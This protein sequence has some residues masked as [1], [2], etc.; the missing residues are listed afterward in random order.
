MNGKQDCAH[1]SSSSEE[2]VPQDW[3]PGSCRGLSCSGAP[4]I[5]SQRTMGRLESS[6]PFTL[7]R[8]SWSSLA[9]TSLQSFSAMKPLE[10]EGLSFV[11]LRT[12]I[13]SLPCF[14]TPKAQDIQFTPEV[15]ARCRSP[16]ASFQAPVP[17]FFPFS[18]PPPHLR[19]LATP[20]CFSAKL[21]PTPA[22]GMGSTRHLVGDRRVSVDTRP[23]QS[24]K[25]A[26][27][28]AGG[29]GGFMISAWTTCGRKKKVG[30]FAFCL[31]FQNSSNRSFKTPGIKNR[32]KPRRGSS[33][34]HSASYP[35]GSSTLP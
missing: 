22:L 11:S 20:W 14:R 33:L 35:N 10:G 6:E 5:V 8:I 31:F 26:K 9:A 28:Q 23:V 30:I 12:L 29:D 3:V 34:I 15:S 24:T 2:D 18:H 17:S 4:G 1:N 16:P 32:A 27:P 21:S 25:A 19:A 13:T 7:S